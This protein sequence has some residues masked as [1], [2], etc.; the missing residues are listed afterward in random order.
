M[1]FNLKAENKDAVILA[2]DDNENILE[3]IEAILLSAGFRNIITT[4][5][6]D[7]SVYLFNK[8]NPDVVLLDLNM[9]LMD[10]F[11]VLT[12]LKTNFN[13]QYLPV[14]VLTGEDNLEIKVKALRFGAKDFIR[15]PF[16]HVEMLA[17]INIVISMSSFYKELIIRN[18]SLDS[19]VNEQSSNL[20]YAV[21]KKEEAEKQLENI[22]L[23]DK[24]T[25]LPNRYL[26]EDRLSQLINTGQRNR[27]KVAVIVLGFDDY[28]DINNTIGYTIYDDLLRKLTERLKRIIR[29]SDTVSILHDGSKGTVLSRIGDDMFSIIVPVFETLNDIETIINR[30]FSILLEPIG[31]PDIMF[32]ISMH[33]GVSYFPDHGATPADL[34]QSASK[35][36][37]FARN[38]NVGYKVYDIATDDIRKNQLNMMADLKNAI[39][40]D[41]LEIYYQPKIKLSDDSIYGCEALIRWN[42]SEYGM[43]PPDDFIPMAEKTGTIRLLTKWVVEKAM[44]QWSEWD[45]QGIELKIAIN[46]SAQDLRDIYFVGMVKRSLEKFQVNP[47][48]IILEVTETSMM[49]D[50]TMSMSTLSQLSKLGVMLSVDDYGTGYSSLAYLKS[51]PVD[52]IKIDQSFVL[53]MDRD[54]GSNVIVKSTIE[55]AHNLGYRVVAEGIENKETYKILQEYGCD[56]G[57]GYYMSRPLP[58]KELIEWFNEKKAQA[59]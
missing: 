32:D 14:I 50:M 47:I 27:T 34:I 19:V 45:A 1:K 56:I 17:R 40:N 46:L 42:H 16:E 51:L 26:F 36:L 49:Q 39:M 18:K 25:G 59:I 5:K 31:M 12:A 20:L 23:H 7:E 10:G 22:L 41:E 35:A 52:E 4:V 43:I 29:D 37:Y 8:H 33:G 55:L 21:K 9:P 24:V 6:P 2:I 57:Q 48:C 30:C 28:T 15:K 11:D 54:K 53:N 3:L 13:S 38:D 44:S 58:E